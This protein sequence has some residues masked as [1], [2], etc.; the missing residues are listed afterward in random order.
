M[1]YLEKKGEKLQEEITSK[2]DLSTRE[3]MRALS[4]E[5]GID[6]SDC[7]IMLDSLIGLIKKEVVEGRR[8][9]FI[10]FG[11]FFLDRDKTIR[12]AGKKLLD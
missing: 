3:I 2:D 11:E 8:F 1:Q 7:R 5:T 10:K 12:F 4:R 9:R 6:Q